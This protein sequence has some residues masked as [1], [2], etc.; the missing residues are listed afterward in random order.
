MKPK[1]EP[2]HFLIILFFAIIVFSGLAHHISCIKFP[3]P[4]DY[5]EG[6]VQYWVNSFV[7]DKSLYPEIQQFPPYM[8]NPYTPLY[9]VFA[10]FLNRLMPASYVFLSGRLLSFLSLILSC[11]LIF[12]IA[13]R[14]S[15]KVAGVFAAGIFF[16]SPVVINYGSI[17]TVDMM[18][19]CLG[20]SAIFLAIRKSNSSGVLSGILSA[21]AI[22]T[23]PVFVLPAISIFISV[24][25]NKNIRKIY[26]LASFASCLFLAFLILFAKNKGIFT[27]LIVMNILPLSLSHFVNLFSTVAPRHVILFIL[28]GAFVFTNKNKKDPFYWYCTL[29]L[30][31]LVFSAKIGS[32]AN[33][34]LEIIAVSSIASGIIL[35]TIDAPLKQTVLLSCIAQLFLFLPFKPAPVF[36]RTYGQ[37]IPTSLSTEPDKILKEAG[38]LITGE[39]LSCSDPILSEDIGWL[40][41]CQKNV[42]IEPYQFSQLAKYK[43]WDETPIVEM[44]KEKQFNLIVMNAGSFEK[45][46]VSFTENM[47]RVIKEH[48]TIKRVIGNFYLLEPVTWTDSIQAN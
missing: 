13:Q 47:L 37:E 8:H 29:S 25:Y 6:V 46:C 14:Y 36:T 16:C 26:F 31:T 30:L 24:L 45:N 20:L 2:I 18:A 15:S 23:K 1:I 27:H 34:F 38:D 3:Y 43:K 10:G 12:L 7:K 5:R 9:I 22:L 48:Y 35:T 19:L 17:E 42:Y 33:Y 39:I 4:I 44:I 21:A 32:E 11:F 40:V 41:L 28:L